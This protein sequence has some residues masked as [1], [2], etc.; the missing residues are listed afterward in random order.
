MQL[1]L[2]I[3]TALAAFKATTGALP[4]S[5]ND[6]THIPG[7]HPRQGRVPLLS[8]G[9]SDDETAIQD[10]IKEDNKMTASNCGALLCNGPAVP[11]SCTRVCS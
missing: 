2:S 4:V 6:H 7:M 8:I 11:G 10:N 5:D 1:L 3:L 9:A